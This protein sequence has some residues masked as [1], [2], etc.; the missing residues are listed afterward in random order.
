MYG[1]DPSMFTIFEIVLGIW[2]LGWGGHIMIMVW[3]GIIPEEG[4]G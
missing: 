2:V 1:G 4:L 3:S